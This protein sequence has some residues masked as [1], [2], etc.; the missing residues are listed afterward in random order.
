M[1]YQIAAGDALVACIGPRT[2]DVAR[3][4]GLPV[5]LVALEA[6]GEGIIRALTS[7]YAK[8]SE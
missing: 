7:Y 4:A 1:G 6:T 8:I 2:A 5:D 3:E